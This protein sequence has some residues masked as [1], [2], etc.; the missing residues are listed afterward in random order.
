MRQAFMSP[1]S[2]VVGGGGEGGGGGGEVGATLAALGALLSSLFVMTSEA[3]P[4]VLTD[5]EASARLEAAGSEHDGAALG[6][7]SGN[8]LLLGGPTHN[9]LTAQLAA[10]WRQ[11]GHAA[12]WGEG[13]ALSLGGCALPT[14]GVGAL[15]LGPRPG[16]GLALVIS[17]DAAGLRDAVAAGEPTIPP[18]AR[19]PFSNTLPDFFVTGRAFASLGYGGV[20]AAGFFGPRWE[21]SEQIGA[22]YFAAEC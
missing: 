20:L 21:L 2:I 4:P 16:G 22:S 10:Y 6:W 3:S 8:L 5:A 18:M 19:S 1:F 11:I 13:D 12:S 14:R 7:P 17:G 15:V 9:R